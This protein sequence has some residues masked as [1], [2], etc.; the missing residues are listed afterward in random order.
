MKL[1][2]G[3]GLKGK[4]VCQ[5]EESMCKGPEP[6]KDPVWVWS[7]DKVPGGA[8]KCTSEER[9]WPMKLERGTG[10]VPP[11]TETLG[12][13]P[14]GNGSQE[15][16]EQGRVTSEHDSGPMGE[17]PLILFSIFYTFFNGTC[18]IFIIKKINF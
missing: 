13:D 15:D 9:A 8:G 7:K 16:W 12:L 10:A 1:T 3:Q 18:F 4:S 5:G 17:F 14:V 11:K 2:R 6:N